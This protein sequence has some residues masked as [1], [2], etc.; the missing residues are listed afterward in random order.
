M[1]QAA[2]DMAVIVL[3]T[4]FAGI[5]VLVVGGLLYALVGMLG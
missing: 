3:A 2:A 4:L 5:A 1:H